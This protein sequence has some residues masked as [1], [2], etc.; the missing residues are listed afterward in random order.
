MF[1]YLRK[2]GERPIDLMREV[3]KLDILGKLDNIPEKEKAKIAEQFKYWAQ[4]QGRFLFEPAKRAYFWFLK[5]ALIKMIVGGNRCLGP[6]EM[7]YDPVKGINR[8]ISEIDGVFNVLSWNG[9]RFVTATAEKPLKKGEDILYSVIIGPKNVYSFVSTKEHQVLTIEGYMSVE[10]AYKHKVKLIGIGDN[11]IKDLF[12][13][14]DKPLPFY[15][16]HVPIYNNYYH[17]GIIHHN[18]GKTATCVIDVVAQAE[19]WHPLQRRNLEKLW[20]EAV[21]EEVRKIAGELLEKRIWIADPPIDARCVTI[22]FSNY[23]EK[24]IGPEYIKWASN[25]ELKKIWYDNDK[26]RKIIWKNGS[27]VEFMTYEQDLYAH[28]GSARDVVHFDEEPPPDY[29][30][31]NLMRVISKKGRIIIGM[32]AIKGVTWVEDQL[33]RKAENNDPD[34]F[35]IRLRTY[36]NP[37]NTKKVV[38]QIRAQCL[39]EDEIAIRIEGE[40]RARGGP[41]Y[42]MYRDTHPW[43]IK[44]FKIPKNIGYLAMAV[45]PHPRIEH[46][47]LWVWVD[48]VGEVEVELSDGTLWKTPKL[49]ENELNFFACAEIF[50]NGTIPE[51]ADLIRFKENYDDYLD[52]RRHDFFI[53]DPSAWNQDQ[54]NPAI[55]ST[56]DL[57]IELGF[58]PTKGSQ[59]LV[60]THAR[61][62]GLFKMGA[63]LKLRE[64]NEFPQFMIFS[65]LSRLRWEIKHYRWKEPRSTKR[66][67]HKIAERPVDKDD[68]LL[69]D[70]RR[71]IEYFEPG[72]FE[73]M[74]TEPLGTSSQIENI[75]REHGLQKNEGYEIIGDI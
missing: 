71:I 34:V 21:D 45:D 59:N 16:F 29:F 61:M 11:Y 2:E 31:E 72:Q 63:A 62:G 5:P 26:K 39:D 7:I 41:V 35:G 22:D 43:V 55:K 6:D 74:D 33:W 67:G 15:D 52:G 50:E 46:G 68:H 20:K 47:V 44:P 57:F 12:K 8:K 17:A 37:A 3:K 19:G 65:N 13:I 58:Y 10:K 69:E 9:K 38:E 51:L 42:K 60:G 48:D 75:L 28:G 23:V 36:D 49:G 70:A 54:R 66:E 18:S 25:A 53:L 32:T 24:T 1:W 40:F 14:S 30:Q 73:I 27:F 64:H 56:A 4:N